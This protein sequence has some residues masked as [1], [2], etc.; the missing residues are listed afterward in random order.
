MYH[1]LHT[2]CPDAHKQWVQKELKYVAAWAA[3]FSQYSRA[4]YP[5][6]FYRHCWCLLKPQ[7]RQLLEKDKACC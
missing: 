2:Y 3:D 4:K 5:V 1:L 6:L 7:N